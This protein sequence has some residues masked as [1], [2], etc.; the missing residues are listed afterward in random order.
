MVNQNIKS[1]Y[2][3]NKSKFIGTGIILIGLLLFAKQ[4]GLFFISWD[5]LWPV[6]LIIAGLINYFKFDKK[7]PGWLI[8]VL[9]GSLFLLENIDPAFSFSKYTWPAVVIS[10]GLWT[11]FGRNKNENSYDERLKIKGK[12]SSFKDGYSETINTSEETKANQTIMMI[13]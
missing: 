1:T 3:N 9:I 10:I 5:L 4:L 8:P 11:L 2:K 12:Y 6:I 13:T 7:K